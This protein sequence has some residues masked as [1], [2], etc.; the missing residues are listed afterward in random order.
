MSRAEINAGVVLALSPGADVEAMRAFARRA[1][2]DARGELEDASGVRW[3]FHHEEPARLAGDDPRRPSDFLDEASL[4]MVEGPY[5]MVLVVTDVGLVSRKRRVVAGLASSVSH[6]AVLSTRKLLIAPRGKP[7]RRLDSDE[8]RANAAALLLHLTGHLLGLDHDARSGGAMAPYQFREELRQIPR[9]PPAARRELARRAERFPEREHTGQGILGVL[10]FHLMSLLRHPVLALKPLLRNR[11]PLLPLAL[12]SLATA[13]V[14]PTFIL[15]FTA[16]I[17][18]VG[19]NLPEREAWGFAIISV[20]A[21]T[22]Y[23]V[24]VQGLFFPHKEKRV[25]TEH[26]A[27]VNI[28]ILLTMLLAM[29]GLFLMVALLMLAVEV[30]IFPPG[31]ISTWP[32]LQDPEVTLRDRFVLAAFISTVGVL[33]GALAGG[34]E[35][36]TVIRHLALFRDDP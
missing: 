5:D 19:L 27:V 25:I 17:W 31:L 24:E 3:I 30:F 23:L 15:V 22:W 10:W 13:A 6:V 28:S 34:V 9:F 35:S 18:D 20:L 21:A 7:V 29:L 8:V 14:A 33:T 32:T 12:P 1:A 16:E 4:R 11:A 2:E 26:M 36:R